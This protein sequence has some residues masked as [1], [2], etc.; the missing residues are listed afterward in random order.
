M[1]PRFPRHLAA[2]KR[3]AVGLG[4]DEGI[5]VYRLLSIMA[6]G[7]RIA[8]DGARMQAKISRDPQ[9]KKFLIRQSRHEQF[10]AFVFAWAADVVASAINA[11]VPVPVPPVMA[12]WRQQIVEATRHE[13]LAESL[14]I[15]QVYLEGLGHIVLQQLDNDLAIAGNPLAGLRRLILRQEA[16]H[17]EFGLRLLEQEV[18]GDPALGLRLELLG[19][20]LRAQAEN[21]LEDLADTFIAAETSHENLLQQLHAQ[22]PARLLLNVAR[23]PA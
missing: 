18:A 19:Y 23:T 8:M 3:L 13:Q 1:I 5:A 12:L 4:E 21:L 6:H 9:V 16:Q 10:H 7:E 20:R 15:Q 22:L 11:S 14:L 2:I 17:H